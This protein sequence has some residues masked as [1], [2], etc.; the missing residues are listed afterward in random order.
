MSDY[1][2]FHTK[3]PNGTQKRCFT[4]PYRQYNDILLSDEQFPT[5]RELMEYE[6][7]ISNSIGVKPEKTNNPEA[8]LIRRGIFLHFLR[9]D[10]PSFD[11][12]K[13]NIGSHE[14]WYNQKQFV[15]EGFVSYIKIPLD[16]NKSYTWWISPVLP[17]KTPSGEYGYCYVCHKVQTFSEEYQ[18]VTLFNYIINFK[19]LLM[20]E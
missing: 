10:I 18:E 8:D 5:K 1:E 3:T 14:E 9:L 13:S 11:I 15:M 4:R 16:E 7:W 19:S 20:K 12:T 2:Y 6:S 17:K